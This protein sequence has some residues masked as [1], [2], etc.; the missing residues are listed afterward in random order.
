[1]GPKGREKKFFKIC[2]MWS[3]GEEKVQLWVMQEK[4]ALQE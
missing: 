4:Q 2:V 1:M 3:T